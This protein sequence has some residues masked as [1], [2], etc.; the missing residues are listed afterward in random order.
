MLTTVFVA[1]PMFD[2][3]YVGMSY[4]GKN[5][6][7]LPISLPSAMNVEAVTQRGNT[8]FQYMLS[9]KKPL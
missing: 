7:Y 8:Q 3:I 2:C 6:N 1:P 4:I 5:E 9:Y